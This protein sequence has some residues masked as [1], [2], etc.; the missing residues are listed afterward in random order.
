MASGG[1]L[2]VAGFGAVSRLDPATGRIETRVRTPDT[3]DYSQIAV[4]E[5]SV[6][7]TGGGAV[8]RI[9]PSTNRVIA[10]VHLAGSVQG[11]AAEAGRIWV[12]RPTSSGPGELI[13]I[14]PRTNRVAG[15]PIKVGPGPGQVIYGQGAVW[16]QNTSPASVVRV[17]PAT[18]H[19][20]TVIGTRAL[21]PGSPV[22]GAIAVGYGSLWAAS[23]GFLTRVDPRTGQVVAS[24]RIPRGVAVAIGAGEVW[25]LAYPRSSSPTL[26][27]PIK[28]TAALWEVDPKSNRIIGKP[29]RLDALQPIAV[30]A[31]QR[32]VWVADYN[33]GTVTRLRLVADTSPAAR[34]ADRYHLN[35]DGIGNI[36]FG[37]APE[38]VAAALEPVFGRPARASAASRIGY[39]PSICGFDHQI[40]WTSLAAR[41][42]GSHSD[43]LTVYFKH[44]RFVGYSYGPPY[45]GPYAPVVRKGV[46]LATSKGL[47]L[48]ESLARGRRLYGRAFVVT[49]QAQGTP[50]SQRLERLPTWDVQTASGRIYAFIDSPGGPLSTY[51]RTIGSISAGVIPNTPCR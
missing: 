24:A 41:P 50:P 35:G 27:Y 32:N 38:L 47:G 39:V 14:D 49:N 25:V 51:Q 43:G 19:V 8:Y 33:R 6:W 34:L 36:R 7:I 45:G 30:T 26:F 11:I 22:A 1:A 18:G 23:N 46:M 42:N 13:R 16:V 9:D 44:S 15:P 31:T 12:T 10:I 28:H 29:I 48:D 37:Q 3:G 2:W 20:S 17:D 5:G 40:E 21:A 4:G